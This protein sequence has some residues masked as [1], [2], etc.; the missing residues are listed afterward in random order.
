MELCKCGH[1]V[2]DHRWDDEYSLGCCCC[3]CATF[4]PQDPQSF[5]GHTGAYARI[6][7]HFDEIK[8]QVDAI[9]AAEDDLVK[10]SSLAAEIGRIIVKHYHEFLH[11]QG[12]VDAAATASLDSE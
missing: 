8:E 1:P 12:A 4:E 3:V 7:A 6:E 2:D 10:R 9:L 11:V 5:R